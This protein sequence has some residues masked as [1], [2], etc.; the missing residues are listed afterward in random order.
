[1]SVSGE[2]RT[3]RRTGERLPRTPRGEKYIGYASTS[4]VYF[5][6]ISPLGIMLISTPQHEQGTSLTPTR[7]DCVRGLG[8]GIPGQSGERENIIRSRRRHF[9]HK[10]STRRANFFALAS[11]GEKRE[12]H[13]LGLPLTRG[14][15]GSLECSLLRSFLLLQANGGFGESGMAWTIFEASWSDNW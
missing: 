14:K 13:S 4:I 10:D 15:R 3:K 5:P 2:D 1:M 8:G 9:H 6:L 11:L 7:V 12:T